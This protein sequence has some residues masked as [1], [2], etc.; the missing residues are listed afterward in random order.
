MVVK[1]IIISSGHDDDTDVLL[2]CQI[3]VVGA[4]AIGAVG[5]I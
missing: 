4:G 2:V 5:A 3:V 1:I